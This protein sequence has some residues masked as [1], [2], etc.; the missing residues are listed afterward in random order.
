[1][2]DTTGF[3]TSAWEGRSPTSSRKGSADHDAEVQPEPPRPLPPED[4]PMPNV[5][6][7]PELP[8]G[9]GTGTA[10]EETMVE[11]FISESR[12]NSKGQ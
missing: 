3:R 4:F 8:T 10:V 6:M 7:P 2:E 11:E 5:P 1:V 12:R 9:R